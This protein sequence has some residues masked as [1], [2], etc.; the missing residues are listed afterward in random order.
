MNKEKQKKIDSLKIKAFDLREKVDM[1]EMQKRQIIT[2]YNKLIA[3]IS[4][5]IEELK[6]TKQ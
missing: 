2:E 4:K 3:E 5:L 6:L 1:I